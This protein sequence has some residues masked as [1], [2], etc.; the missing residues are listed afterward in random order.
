[1]SLEFWKQFPPIPGC[2]SIKMKDDIQAKIYE[3][4]KDMT[5]EERIAYF[6]DAGDRLREED[7]IV[8]HDAE[9]LGVKEESAAYETK[10]PRAD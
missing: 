3:E 6:T 5:A 10:P 7:A 8:A 4:I 2:D 1:M 9:P